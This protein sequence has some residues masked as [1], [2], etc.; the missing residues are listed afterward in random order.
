M[1]PIRRFAVIVLTCCFAIGIAAAQRPLQPEDLYQLKS[2][3]DPRLS[4]D[5]KLVAYVVARAEE[6]TNKRY[7][8]IWYAPVD[9]SREPRRL[10]DPAMSSSS[11]RWSP[12]GRSLAFLSARPSAHDPGEAPAVA[13]KAQVYL[14]SFDGGEAQPLTSLRNG[15]R[16]FEWSPDGKRL[17]VVST[18]GPSDNVKASE[19]SDTHHYTHATMKL[20]GRGYFDD[21]RQHLWVVKVPSGESKQITDG[22]WDDNSP[23]WSP[24][25]SRVAFVADRSGQYW[26]N[27]EKMDDLWVVSAEGGVPQKIGSHALSAPT[28]S[29]DGTS[30]AYFS[31]NFQHEARKLLLA[32]LNGAAEPKLL[33]GDLDL[34]VRDVTWAEHGKLIYFLAGIRGTNQAF[35]VDLGSGKVSQVTTGERSVKAI[36]ICDASNT[37]AMAISDF[38][39]PA[40]LFVARLDDSQEKQVSHVNA[41]VLEPLKLAAASRVL[42]KSGDGWDIDGFLVKPVGFEPGKRYPLILFIHGGP[43]GMFAADWSIQ[44]QAWAAKGWGV[45]FTNPRGSTGYGSKFFNDAVVGEWGG[46]VQSD[47]MTALDGAIA[48]NSWID[49]DRLGVTGCSFGGFSTNWIISHTTR[50][51]AAV[52]MCSISD[53]ISDEGTRDGY[54]GHAHDF[55]G[56]LYQNFDLYWKY[57]PVRY[58][59]NVKTPTLILHG[60]SDARVPIEQAEQWFRALRHFN[61]PA[62]LVTFPHEYHGGLF[63]GEPRH[64][65]EAMN[66][67]IYWF[68]KYL[69]GNVQA[70]APDSFP[71]NQIADSQPA[72]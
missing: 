40:E 37:M 35:R 4:P 15:V 55:Q 36:D 50:F 47:L 22:S 1:E 28:W 41:A 65:V 10:S 18:A 45:L 34:S 9:S 30:V 60:E 31:A 68:E 24:D 3:S 49:S 19:R 69:D 56:D 72:K 64:V 26:D 39:H 23:Q 51:K 17:V 57:S 53:Y 11:P 43:Q 67:Q 21:K 58:A 25:G 38:Q 6:K 59:A 70:K 42:T 62:E 13:P 27:L 16:S 46:K 29:P 33:A 44:V 66:W 52:P 8:E 5:G 7:N 54:Y 48:K 12:D 71:A 14:L 61:V 32:S 20:D 2:V 63:N